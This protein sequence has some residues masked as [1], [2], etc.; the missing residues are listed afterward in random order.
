MQDRWK[1]PSLIYCT[2]PHTVKL[3][4][5]ITLEDVKPCLAVNT[6]ANLQTHGCA[7]SCSRKLLIVK[8]QT[9]ML[10]YVPGKITKTKYLGFIFTSETTATEKLQ[11]N[12]STI[13]ATSN[14]MYHGFWVLYLSIWNTLRTFSFLLIALTTAV[15]DVSQE[16]E[17]LG[18]N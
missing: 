14:I 7:Q 1:N 3:I 4:Y 10:Q 6:S 11:K 13:I 12:K 16:D 5:L 18:V 15:L 9:N 17:S 8:M 2:F